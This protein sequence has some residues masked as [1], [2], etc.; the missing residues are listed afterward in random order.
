MYNVRCVVTKY[1]LF[2]CTLV[3]FSM[4]LFH[5]GNVERNKQNFNIWVSTRKTLK[6]LRQL[7][8]SARL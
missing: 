7:T 5:V 1:V 2:C 8:L 4:F 6:L 3:L